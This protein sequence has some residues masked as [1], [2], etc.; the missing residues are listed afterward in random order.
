MPG[1]GVGS[2]LLSLPAFLRR[3]LYRASIRTPQGMKKRAGTVLVTAVGMFGKGDGWGIPLSIHTLAVTLGGIAEKAIVL[4]G[5]TEIREFLNVTISVDHD[6]V[7][8]APAA[9]F[10]QRL[11]ELVESGHGLYHGWVR[12][13]N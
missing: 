1:G 8:G 2:L 10:A 6:I 13:G 4:D 12:T 11:K 5:E 3:L 9:R 7:D